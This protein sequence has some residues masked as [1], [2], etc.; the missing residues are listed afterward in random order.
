VVLGFYPS[1]FGVNEY[2]SIEDMIW[3]AVDFI[4]NCRIPALYTTATG[5]GGKHFSRFAPRS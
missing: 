3:T 5:I 4:C 1:P 2:N